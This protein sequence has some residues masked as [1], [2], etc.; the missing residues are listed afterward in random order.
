MR[1]G[2]VEARRDASAGDGPGEWL[3]ADSGA[4]FELD[5]ERLPLYCDV[6]G[7]DASAE[8]GCDVRRPCAVLSLP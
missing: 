5:R 8:V 7:D 2:S 3:S 1:L 6:S 4:R